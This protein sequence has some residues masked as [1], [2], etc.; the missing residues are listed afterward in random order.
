MSIVFY[1][2]IAVQITHNNRNTFNFGIN[3]IWSKMQVKIT[4]E[5]VELSYY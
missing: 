2:W 3:N 5:I 1:K 4:A